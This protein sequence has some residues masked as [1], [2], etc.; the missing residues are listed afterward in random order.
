MLKF[1]ASSLADIMTEPKSKIETLSVG[2]KTTIEKMAK[3][4]V[5]GYDS[6]VTSKY[7]TKGVECED[8][9]IEL[10]N[11]VLFTDYKKNTER[12]TN[13]WITGEADIVTPDAILDIKTS[14]SIETFPALAEACDNKTYWWQMQAYMWLFDKKVA[15]VCY[16]LIDTPEY[17]IG[18]ENRSLHQVSHIAPELRVTRW[19][20]E[21]DDEAIA[22]IPVKVEAA[23]TYYHEI[24]DRIAKEHS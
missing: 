13:D 21:R 22:K 1:R 3:E 12:K 17:L 24:I 7:M 9:S 6:I 23:R 20:I 15:E 2:A 4:F 10:L 19:K 14:W 16:C 5:Y 8:Q 18:Y 11:S